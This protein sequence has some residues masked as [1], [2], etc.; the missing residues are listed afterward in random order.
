MQLCH[1]GGN[2]HYWL[3]GFS[4]EWTLVLLLYNYDWMLGS[5]SNHRPKL[6]LHLIFAIFL[7]FNYHGPTRQLRR[8]CNCHK[9]QACLQPIIVISFYWPFITWSVMMCP[10]QLK[11]STCCDG[12][13]QWFNRLWFF[14]IMYQF[15]YSLRSIMFYVFEHFSRTQMTY[16]LK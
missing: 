13:H 5:G 7:K 10:V 9:I 11:Q 12:S 16:F 14:L 4:R 15:A 2:T 1:L 6:T 8:S 3:I